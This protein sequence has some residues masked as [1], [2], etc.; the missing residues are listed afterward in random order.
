LGERR[1]G[2]VMERDNQ[3]KEDEKGK[4]KNKKKEE[5]MIFE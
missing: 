2:S 3:K 1:I 4:E 5:R